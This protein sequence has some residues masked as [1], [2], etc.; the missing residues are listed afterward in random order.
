V[1][2][3]AIQGSWSIS[4]LLKA[5][6]AFTGDVDTVAMIGLGTGANAVEIEQDLP[7]YLFTG[8]GNWRFG[9]EY[10]KALDEKLSAKFELS[11]NVGSCLDN[12]SWKLCHNR[13]IQKSD[14][15]NNSRWVGLQLMD[16][17]A[18]GFF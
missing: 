10:L 5:C 2:L 4:E 3:T 18:E 9:R 11:K 8:L 7:E 13:S 1:G 15:S 16:E 17:D 12:L 14:R 6:V